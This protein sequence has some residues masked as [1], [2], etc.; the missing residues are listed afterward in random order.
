[1][2][3][4][5]GDSPW[6]TEWLDLGSNAADSHRSRRSAT[7]CRSWSAARGE[8][9]VRPPDL[10]RSPLVSSACVFGWRRPVI[11]LPESD[12]GIGDDVLIHELA[13]VAR[14]DCL[15]K[16]LAECAVAC[17]GFSLFCGV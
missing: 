9:G 15:W 7:A 13:H 17:S 1:M 16:L 12:A 2:A 5:F 14:R 4:D 11:V 3:L 6:A 10:K 8:L